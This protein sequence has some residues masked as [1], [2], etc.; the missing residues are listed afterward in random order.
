M[1][2]L[3]YLF[4]IIFCALLYHLIDQNEQNNNDPFDN[5]DSLFI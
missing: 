3:I 5:D 1:N 4:V 2:P